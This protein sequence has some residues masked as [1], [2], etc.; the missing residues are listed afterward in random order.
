MSGSYGKGV[1]ILFR[2]LQQL[3]SKVIQEAPEDIQLCEFECRKLECTMGDWEKCE[4]RLLSM[5][6]HQKHN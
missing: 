6:E 3:R 2:L 4:R 1:S 5:R